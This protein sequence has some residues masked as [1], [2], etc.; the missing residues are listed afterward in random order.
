MDDRLRGLQRQFLSTGDP[1]LLEQL[2]ASRQ[3][4]GLPAYGPAV[5]WLE[6]Q[7]RLGG[8]PIKRLTAGTAVEILKAVIYARGWRPD[9]RAGRQPGSSRVWIS[10]RETHRW[11]FEKASIKAEVGARGRWVRDRQLQELHTTL[12]AKKLLGDLLRQAWAGLQTWDGSSG[13]AGSTC[14]HCNGTFYA[15]FMRDAAGVMQYQQCPRCGGSGTQGAPM[16]LRDNP[17]SKKSGKNLIEEK[18]LDY[19]RGLPG[20][21]QG[22]KDHKKW[23]GVKPDRASSVLIDDG[24]HGH[25]KKVMVALG[26]VP[27]QHYVV[28]WDSPNKNFAAEDAPDYDPKKD[29]PVHYRHPHN[30]GSEPI[31]ALDP[32]TGITSIVPTDSR[33]Q[34]KDWLHD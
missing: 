2:L 27:E 32:Q 29:G 26:V 5:V 11:S 3:Q 9:M 24:K 17:N 10:P 20:F 31:L 8:T 34:V 18:P 23:H 16:P 4:H 13:S 28:P 25:T 30:E 22:I 12:T 6:A 19:A 7:K 33:T 21:E 14:S 15:P 1:L